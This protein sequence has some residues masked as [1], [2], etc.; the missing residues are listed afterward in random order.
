MYM[1]QTQKMFGW[2]SNCGSDERWSSISGAIEY[3]QKEYK[4]HKY[5]R[6]KDKSGKVVWEK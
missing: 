3:A 2:K 6:I 1:V 5:V 4:H